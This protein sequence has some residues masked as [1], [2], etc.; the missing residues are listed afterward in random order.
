MSIY[1]EELGKAEG[2]LHSAC[3]PMAQVN[4]LQASESPT[5][6]IRAEC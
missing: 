6:F 4:L 5:F 3:L 2:S 1:E